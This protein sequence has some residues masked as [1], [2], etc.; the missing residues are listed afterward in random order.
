MQGKGSGEEAKG[1][2]IKKKKGE[3]LQS[4]Q[5]K[6]KE[7]NYQFNSLKKKIKRTPIN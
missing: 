3:S 2:E 7:K 6:K 1:R 5:Q 4:K